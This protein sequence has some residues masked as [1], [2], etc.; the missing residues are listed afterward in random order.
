MP[1]E[2]EGERMD[3]T[4]FVA[5]YRCLEPEMRKDKPSEE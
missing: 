2:Y 1:V 3:G 5:C 4:K